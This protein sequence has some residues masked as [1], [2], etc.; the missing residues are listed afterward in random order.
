M[1]TSQPNL[2]DEQSIEKL[3]NT[4]MVVAFHKDIVVKANEFRAKNV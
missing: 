1:A 2:Q 4:S 3:Q